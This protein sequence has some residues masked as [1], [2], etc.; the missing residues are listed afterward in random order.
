ML[1]DTKWDMQN[2]IFASAPRPLDLIK[3]RSSPIILLK[4]LPEQLFYS[5]NKEMSPDCFILREEEKQFIKDD[6]MRLAERYFLS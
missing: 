4:H 5:C 6:T 3:L 1:L 2:P